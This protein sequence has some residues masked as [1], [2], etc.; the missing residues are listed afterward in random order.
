M[1]SIIDQ[2]GDSFIVTYQ[3]NPLNT[4]IKHS[5]YIAAFYF[6]LSMSVLSRLSRFLCRTN[7][8][9]PVNLYEL[10]TK[11]KG[12]RQERVNNNNIKAFVPKSIQIVFHFT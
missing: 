2:L 5:Q 6:A 11:A 9:F 3:T 7:D 10:R 8:D 1:K 4:K 12:K